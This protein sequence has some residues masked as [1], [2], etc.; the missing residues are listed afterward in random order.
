MPDK[1]MI[2]SHS[3]L[4]NFENCAL[5]FKYRYIDKVEVPKRDSV[6]AFLGSR[7]HEVLEALHKGVQMGKIWTRD[8]ILRR[9]HDLWEKEKHDEIFIVNRQY[10]LD[11]YYRQGQ[12]ALSDYWDRYQPFDGDITIALE[13]HVSLTLDDGDRYRM[14]GFID[15]ISKTPDGRWQIRD[16]KTKRRL[17]TQEQADNDRQ[18]ALY[19]IG[20]QRMF[21]Q[22][23]EVELIWHYLLFNEEVRSRRDRSDLERLKTETV[24]TIQLAEKAMAEDDFPPHESALCDW[25]DYFDIC[26]AKKH[27]AQVRDLPP[28]EFKADDGVKLADRFAELNSQK[29]EHN[30]KIK[31]IGIELDQLKEEIYRFSEQF[32]IT[33]VYGSTGYLSVKIAETYRPPS[34]E[35]KDE[36]PLREGL[37]E[38]LKS[39]PLWREVSQ[40]TP[41]RLVK[42]Y[43]SGELTEKL[44]RELDNFMIPHIEKRVRLSSPK[45]Y[46]ENFE[47]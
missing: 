34:R 41:A 42:L 40:L 3:R 33:K 13:E 5:Q 1:D 17:P 23:K 29:A 39:T 27:L 8:E 6:E 14:R 44:K 4:E 18:L 16:Y 25:C 7:V 2:W 15:R 12:K 21:P 47:G 19:Q 28:A 30:R 36:R 35:S 24:K 11:D 10:T 31:E 9:F 43:E 26:P 22:A 32:M 37:E 38:F 46:D 20:L 45:D